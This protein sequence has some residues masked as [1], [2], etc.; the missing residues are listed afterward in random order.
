MFVIEVGAHRNEKLKQSYMVKYRSM[1]EQESQEKSTNIA[2]CPK[3][4]S[5]HPSLRTE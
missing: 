4:L 5:I 2:G 3:H 1:H